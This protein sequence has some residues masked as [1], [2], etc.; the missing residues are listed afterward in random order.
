MS[1]WYLG[2]KEQL[3]ARTIPQDAGVYAVGVN[4]D[5]VYD[6]SH[7]DFTVLTPYIL[8]PEQLLTGVTFTNGVLRAANPKWLAAGAGI[9]DKSLNLT[10]LIIYFQL[11]DAGALLAFIDSATVGLPQTL[12]GVTVTALWASAGILKL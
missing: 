6:E 2:G 7:T 10:G 4:E 8:L 5:Y 12:Q 11:A 9:S 3:L 1:G